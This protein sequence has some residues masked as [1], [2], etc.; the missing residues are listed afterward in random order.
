[1][2]FTISLSEAIGLAFAMLVAFLFLLVWLMRRYTDF[3]LHRRDRGVVPAA[4]ERWETLSAPSHS[5]VIDVVPAPDGTVS[6]VA[7]ETTN[8]DT[9]V[10]VR[11]T[12]PLADWHAWVR[13]HRLHR[14][15]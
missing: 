6:Q 9:N 8:P 15:P 13:Q 12:V 5:V 7:Y 11:R 10:L 14:R 4:R 2:F 3:T 1:M